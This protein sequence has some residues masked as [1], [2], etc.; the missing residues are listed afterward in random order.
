MTKVFAIRMAP[1]I[2]KKLKIY[3][4]KN[5]ITITECIT[6]LVCDLLGIKQ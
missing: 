6:K 5:D 3:C 1:E 2:I 4:A